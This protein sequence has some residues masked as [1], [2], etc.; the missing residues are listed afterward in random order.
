MVAWVRWPVALKD[1]G[2]I[3]VDW[4]DDARAPSN[5][6]GMRFSALTPPEK[7]ALDR[8]FHGLNPLYFRK[9]QAE[10]GK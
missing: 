1:Y 5:D 7:K 6:T 2:F 10:D 9:R 3:I 4:P 8:A